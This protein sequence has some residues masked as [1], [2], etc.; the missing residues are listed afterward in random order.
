MG[1]AGR[2]SLLWRGNRKGSRAELK[3]KK[4]KTCTEHQRPWGIRPDI[5]VNNLPLWFFLNNMGRIISG[6]SLAEQSK[7]ADVK[8][9]LAL[10]KEM[11]V[12]GVQSAG[13]DSF[14]YLTNTQLTL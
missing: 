12:R 1:A 10:T 3:I 14:G 2:L 8:L 5:G 11:K 6:L 13:M 7:M 9:V 4:L